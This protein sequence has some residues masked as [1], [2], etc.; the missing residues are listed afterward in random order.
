VSTWKKTGWPITRRI[1]GEVAVPGLCGAA[2]GALAYYEGKTLFESAS[3]GFAAFF[4]V[5]FLQGQVLRV[6]KNVSD[7]QNADEWRSSFATLKDGLDE[8]R[9]QQFEHPAQ[10]RP[11]STTQT[12]PPATSLMDEAHASLQG[13]RYR[14]AVLTAAA[15]FEQAVRRAAVRMSIESNVPLSQLVQSIAYVVKSTDVQRQ[16]LTLVRLRNNLMHPP[17]DNVPLSEDEATQLVEGFDDGIYL[18]GRVSY[19][20]KGGPVEL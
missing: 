18:L 5:F 16:L 4:F 15:A 11:A 12:R 7:K 13:N 1:L 19:D 20:G 10:P 17:P 6:A 9:K 14:A 2:W 3:T 8:L